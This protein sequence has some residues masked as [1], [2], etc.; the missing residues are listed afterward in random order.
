MKDSTPRTDAKPAD[1]RQFET[2]AAEAGLD[3]P[4]SRGCFVCGEENPHG[5]QLR[6]TLVGEKVVSDFELDRN[7]TGFDGRAHGGIVASLLD[8]A[9]GWSTIL[10]SQRFTYT[11]ELNVRYLHPVPV[12]VV[13]RV[14]AWSERHTRRLS[15]PAARIVEP[16]S[17]RT[18]AEGRGKFMMTSA[19]ES[20]QIAEQLIYRQGSWRLPDP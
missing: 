5:L 13:L 15:F 1:S 3:L 2:P 9:M 11:V 4:T 10:V 19:V 20:R 18:L 12:G 8:E 16:Y 6:F 7:R 17:E 14:E